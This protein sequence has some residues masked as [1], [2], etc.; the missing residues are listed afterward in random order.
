[1][2]LETCLFD[3][4]NVLLRFSHHRMCAQ[5]GALCGHSA[6]EIRRKLIESGL[7][8]DFERGRF[9]QE[10]FHRE[11][12]RLV[13]TPLDFYELLHAGSDIFEP[14]EDVAEIVRSVHRQGVRLVLLSNTSRAHFEFIRRNYPLLE[15]FDDY[16]LSYQVG[17]LKPERAI[18]EAALARIH[19][20]P[21]CC[22]YTDDILE[23]V[24]AG[25]RHGLQAEQFIGGQPLAEHLADRGLYVAAFPPAEVRS[26]NA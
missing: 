8:W 9:S 26:V 11:L 20:P 24:E 18:F 14:N 19:C 5:I 7:Q 6:E 23:Y 12:E 16:V 25:R 15:L 3:L 10:Q 17:V 4:G 22:F 2:P 13:Q 1:M 21:E